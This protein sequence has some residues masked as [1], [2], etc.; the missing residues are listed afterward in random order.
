MIVYLVGVEV[1]GSD[2]DVEQVVA[3]GE[4]QWPWFWQRAGAGLQDVGDV[5]GT[6]GLEGEPVGDGTRHCIGG[7]DL[8]QIQGPGG[9]GGG[10][11]PSHL[12]PLR[13]RG[14]RPRLPLGMRHPACLAGYGGLSPSISFILSAP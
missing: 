5:L 2:V 13:I 9:G 6:E 1:R 3:T 7:G 12:P 10:G 11:K 4:L 14:R 8:G